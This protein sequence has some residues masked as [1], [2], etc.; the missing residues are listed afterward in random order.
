MPWHG[1]KISTHNHDRTACL[2]GEQ[3]LAVY[4]RLRLEGVT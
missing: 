1:E 4:A 2:A 3:L